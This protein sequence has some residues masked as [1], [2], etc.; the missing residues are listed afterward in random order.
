M[1]TYE[2]PRVQARITV[3]RVIKRLGPGIVSGASDNDPTTVATLAVIGA[4]TVYGLAWLVLLVIPMLAVVQAIAARVGA[5]SKR[6]LED[7]IR[8]RYGR[9][10]SFAAM[11]A[12]LA[13][14]VITLAADLEGGGAALQMITGVDYRW[15]VAPLA[16]LAAIA[17]IFGRSDAITN[18]LKYV[19]IVF[20]AYVFTAFFSHPDWLAVVR[21]SL[22][23]HLE[24]APAYVSGV[25]ALLGTTLT[26]YAYVWETVETSEKRPP[27]RRIG[28]VQAEAVV[29]IVFAGLIFWFI[30]IATGA[31]LGVHHKTVETAQDAANALVPIAGRNAG[32]LFG[33]GLLGSALIA[34][35]VLAG[36][37]AYVMAE[38]FGWR[39]SLDASFA[40]ADRFYKTLVASLAIG[41]GIALCGV[42]P[43]KLLF[44]SGIAG[45][46]ATPFT[47]AL[48]MLVG[49]SR[50]VMGS[51]IL[52]RRITVAGWFVTAVVTLA[53]VVFLVQTVRGG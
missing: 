19:T 41:A 51:E 26:S 35:P 29:G 40:R 2:E 9:G 1:S 8:Y 6:G 15:F 27:L 22:V 24:A 46:I 49:R 31:T 13:V 43:I 33:I 34:I 4:S 28:L 11:F 53:A 50:K 25:I 16:L 37:S 5:V 30:V 21:G 42:P 3:G 23:P 20:L 38:A 17:L 18:V 10:L 44:I 12:V 32:L 36:T 39:R 45:G 14:N 48:M 47:L 7:C 52:G